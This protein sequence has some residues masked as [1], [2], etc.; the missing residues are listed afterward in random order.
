MLNLSSIIDFN[1]NHN[2]K[3]DELSAKKY[4][5]ELE[6]INKVL[7]ELLKNTYM[8]KVLKH[9]PDLNALYTNL[10]H[11]IV[12]CKNRIEENQQQ[13]SA[14][15]VATF[16]SFKKIMEKIL[17]EIPV[18]YVKNNAIL[19]DVLVNMNKIDGFINNQQNR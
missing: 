12:E 13:M 15:S 16:Y 10:T 5:R 9:K 6:G 7:E 19:K 18:S 8:K 17:D 3:H 1:N 2:L 4:L 11:E 14:I